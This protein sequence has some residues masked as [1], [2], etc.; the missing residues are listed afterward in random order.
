[1]IVPDNDFQVKNGPDWETKTTDD[2]F[3]GKRVVVF[4]LPGAF[5]PTCSSKQLPKYEEMY[6]DF[7]EMGIDEVICV[8]VNDWFV[9]SAWFGAQAIENVK[10]IAD[11]DGSFT[12]KMNMLVDKPLQGFGMRSW[13]YS[14]LVENKKIK[15]MFIEKGLNNQ[16]FDSDPYEVSDPLTMLE[17]LQN[18][19]QEEWVPA[20]QA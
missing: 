12:K 11:G 4:S 19:D 10:F 15:K 1:M 14:M 6:N 17:Y 18:P 9:M 7:K 16:S 13:R 2:Y 3:K 20:A 5:T 8:S